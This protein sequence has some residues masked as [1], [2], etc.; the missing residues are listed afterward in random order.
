MAPRRWYSK[1]APGAHFEV[2]KTRA[3]DVSSDERFIRSLAALGWL[4]RPPVGRERGIW[5]EGSTAMTPTG[6]SRSLLMGESHSRLVLRAAVE[7]D[8]A[9]ARRLHHACCRPWVE[10]VWGWDDDR[11][12]RLFEE[13]WDPAHTMIVEFEGQPVGSLRTTDRADHIFIDD[14]EIHPDHQGQ[15]LG[16]VILRRILTSADSRSLPVALQVIKGNPA[17]RL[18]ERHGFCEIGETDTHFLM[19]RE[20]RRV[21]GS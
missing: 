4:S 6:S 3:I 10:P 11:Q 13:R 15:G 18:Y 1:G 8:R 12:D 2:W 17:R 21:S 20:P 7:A 19:R 14:I 16:T 5:Q 9:F